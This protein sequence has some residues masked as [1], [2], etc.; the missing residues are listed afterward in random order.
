MSMALLLV[1]DVLK[2]DR[3]ADELGHSLLGKLKKL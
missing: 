3:L 1:K 2:I